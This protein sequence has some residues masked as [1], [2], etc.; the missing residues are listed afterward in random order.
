MHLRIALVTMTTGL[1]VAAVTA[2]DALARRAPQ[3][4]GRDLVIRVSGG[5]VSR[6]GSFRIGREPTLA[7][8]RRAFGAPSTTRE[9]G[10]DACQVD[11]RRLRLRVLFANFGLPP[12]GQTICGPRGGSAQTF[13]A[14]GRRVRTWRGLRVGDRSSTIPDRHPSA[15][16]RQGTWWLRTATSP[17]GDESE[18]PVMRA[19]VRDGRVRALAG[20][21]GAAGD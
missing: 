19:V 20:W 2:D 11:W 3:G 12:A 1:V 17:Y 14:R 9:L 15:E 18:Y 21:I 8:A 10:N 13:T 6:I 4:E 5:A 7:R 16:F